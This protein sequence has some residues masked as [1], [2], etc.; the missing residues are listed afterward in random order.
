MSRADTQVLAESEDGLRRKQIRRAL[1]RNYLCIRLGVTR[2][3]EFDTALARKAEAWRW[4]SNE[5]TRHSIVTNKN[6]LAVPGT[7]LSQLSQ[8]I[9][10]QH[11]EPG[12]AGGRNFPRGTC[13]YRRM[14]PPDDPE[15]AE[16][17]RQLALAKLMLPQLDDSP[18]CEQVYFAAL[19]GF[20]PPAKPRRPVQR[21]LG[22][23]GPN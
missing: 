20:V 18:F 14:I 19:Y 7:A 1:P 15:T 10:K 8:L 16:T 9:G 13:H 11:P 4:R 17:R 6:P 21:E 12:Q 5:M 2:R 22:S 3:L 23:F